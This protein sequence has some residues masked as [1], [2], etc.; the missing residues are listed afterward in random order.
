M[1][2][3]ADGNVIHARFSDLP[4]RAQVHP[5]AG[6]GFCL[7][8]GLLHGHPHLH[9]VHVVQQDDVRARSQ[10]LLHLLQSVGLDFDRALWVLIARAFDRRS[11][12]VRRRVSQRGKMIV[13][14]E[15]LVEQTEAVVMAATARHRVLLQPAQAGRG[16]AGVENP[17]AGPL[18]RR[19]KL[20]RQGRDAGKALNKIKRD[21]FRAEDRPRRTLNLQQRLPCFHP[22][23]LP[24]HAGRPRGGRKP[25][26]N[27]LRQWQSGYHHRLASAHHGLPAGAF[28]NGRQRGDVAAADVFSQRQLN[29]PA[30]FFGGE[31][32][33]AISMHPTAKSEKEKSKDK[34]TIRFQPGLR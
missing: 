15:H 20:I 23:A 8:F 7:A 19:D 24:G 31:R 6:L 34:K 13:L 10:G 29:H 17:R 27:R 9:E 18:D 4:D 28:G 21:A 25:S 14:D 1:R 22:I 16:L 11:D 3:S 26:K 32:F 2:Q 33:H 30:D 12:G 5:A